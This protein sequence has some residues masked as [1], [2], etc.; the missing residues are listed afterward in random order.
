MHITILRICE[1]VTLHNRV[2]L[3]ITY[4]QT[5]P[6]AD[7]IKVKDLEMG[8][9]YARLSWWANLMMSPYRSKRKAKE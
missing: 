5:L 4:L 8:R 3:Q 1:S 6:F 2:C 9:N 7:A